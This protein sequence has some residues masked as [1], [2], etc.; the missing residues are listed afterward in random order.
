[1]AGIPALIESL[2]APA[3][4]TPLAKLQIVQSLDSAILGGPDPVHNAGIALN[5]GAVPAMVR[6][7]E[8]ENQP[9]LLHS[10]CCILAR[11][12]GARLEYTQRVADAGAFLKLV[13][14]LASNFPPLQFSSMQAINYTMNGSANRVAAAVAAG[15]LKPIVKLAKSTDEQVQ[16]MAVSAGACCTYMRAAHEQQHALLSVLP[17]RC[18]AASL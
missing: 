8:S 16:Q 13:P 9:M 17:P 12:S 11:I 10:A 4:N 15:A 3:A 18:S 1:M 14:L 7:L 6:I 2:Q 5:S